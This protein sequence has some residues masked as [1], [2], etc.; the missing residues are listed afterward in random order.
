MLEQVSILCLEI[1]EFT[2]YS[3]YLLLRNNAIL[4]DDAID[5]TI[6]AHVKDIDLS[7]DMYESTYLIRYDSA[8]KLITCTTYDTLQILSSSIFVLWAGFLVQFLLSLFLGSFYYKIRGQRLM[9]YKSTVVS[10]ILFICIYIGM[11][12]LKGIYI[13][14]HRVYF[15]YG[16]LP[17]LHE[18]ILDWLRLARHSGVKH[19]FQSFEKIIEDSE[20]FFE[21]FKYLMIPQH[22]S[23]QIYHDC[24]VSDLI[25]SE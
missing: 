10:I 5:Y 17:Q 22:Y 8:D 15:E 20:G 13:T 21:P 19:G 18:R 11:G 1:I 9:G 16:I 25:R 3:W 7:Y 12:M 2:Y 6:G 4:R 24:R 23:Y 14:H